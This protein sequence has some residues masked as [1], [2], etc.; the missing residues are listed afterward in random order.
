MVTRA[1]NGGLSRNI[2]S[3]KKKRSQTTVPFV[4][5]MGFEGGFT[6]AP[7]INSEQLL[8]NK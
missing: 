4:M 5:T 7:D 8:K 2:R 6:A 3:T 1:G